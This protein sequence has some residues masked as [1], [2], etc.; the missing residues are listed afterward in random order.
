MRTQLLAA[1]GVTIGLCAL[2]APIPVPTSAQ[3]AKAAAASPT[4]AS[5]ASNWTAPKTPWGHP[6]LQGVWTTDLEIGVPVDR[7]VE[8]GEKAMLTDEEFRQRAAAL[9]KKY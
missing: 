1:C 6:D 2:A 4:T 5:A 3:G 9:K 7:P 8:L